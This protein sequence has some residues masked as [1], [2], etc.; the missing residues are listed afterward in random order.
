MQVTVEDVSSVKK[1]L[2][3]EVPEDELKRE[4]DNAYNQLKKNAKVK[5][6]RPGK[7]PRSVLESMF[8]KDV[9]SDVASRLIQTSFVE[10]IKETDLK[11]IGTPKIDPQDL[12]T[13]GSYKYDAT[14]E[15][16]PE[17][18]AIDFKNLSLKKTRYTAGDKEVE[19]QL[20]MLRKNMAALE[21]IETDRSVENED[22]VLLD[23]EGL[24]DGK[25][26]EE[27]QRTE[28]FTLKVGDGR[29][30]KEIDENLIGMKS[31]DEKEIKVVFPEDYFNKKLAGHEIDFQITLKEIRQEVLPELNDELAGKF[32]DY[33][34]IDELKTAIIENL[35]QGYK[36][37]TEQELNEQIFS[38]FLEKTSFEAPDS[39]IEYE[40]NN[41][42]DDAERSFSNQNVSMEDLG[43]TREKLSEKYRDTAEKQVKRHL[44]LDK[45]IEQEELTLSD[46]DQE[47][48]FKDIAAQFNQP[49]EQIKNYYRENKE[50]LEYFKHTLLEKNAITL[51][52]E[53]SKI[54]EVEPEADQQTEDKK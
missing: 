50:N 26:F 28:N 1:I 16:K 15:I 48:G 31:G 44:I 22:F 13:K 18:A 35:T 4:L 51:I 7:A 3:I 14:V 32:G 17:I 41:I 42:I 39:M 9:H 11:V 21:K 19:T 23:Y 43:F 5:G 24:K 10:A 45:I 38:A 54:E 53:S 20:E 52:I 29:I 27:T 2:H 36:K 30:S 49:L 47:A 37:R 34:N 46:E 6:F 40:L 33:K 12:E 25:P 8:K